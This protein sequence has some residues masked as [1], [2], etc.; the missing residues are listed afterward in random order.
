[1]SS[2]TR[3]CYLRSGKAERAYDK[4]NLNLELR[5]LQEPGDLVIKRCYVVTKRLDVRG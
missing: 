4:R 3:P 5:V 1:M 2:V